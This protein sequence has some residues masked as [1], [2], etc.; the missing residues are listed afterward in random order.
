MCCAS[1]ELDTPPAFNYASG[2]DLHKDSYVISR[3]ARRTFLRLM[4]LFL[5]STKDLQA[6]FTCAYPT[7]RTSIPA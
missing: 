2:A 7:H 4:M 6:V 3:I 1:L 5:V